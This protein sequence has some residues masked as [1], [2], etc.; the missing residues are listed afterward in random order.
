MAGPVGTAPAQDWPCLIA[1]REAWRAALAAAGA[2]RVAIHMEDSFAFAGALL[3]AW[4]AGCTAI[5]PGDATEITAASLEDGADLFLGGFPA[6]ETGTRRLLAV[7]QPGPAPAPSSVTF[8]LP[9]P[10]VVIFTSGSSGSPLAV[11]KTASDLQEEVATLESVLGAELPAVTAPGSGSAACVLATVSHQHIYGLLFR[12]LW[13]L[14]AGRP[15]SGEP[16]RFPEELF[17]SIRAAA[18]PVLLVAS[19]A[20]LRRLPEARFPEARPGDARAQIDGKSLAAVFS[21]GGPLPWTC[22]PACAQL[23]GAVP[24]EIYGSSETGGIAWRRRESEAMPWTLF[25]RVEIDAG[26]EGNLVLTQSPHM[27]KGR[28]FATR[29][30]VRMLPQGFQLQGRLDRI[31]KLEEKRLSLEAMEALLRSHPRV[32]EAHLTVSTG[33]GG[34]EG[35]VAGDDNGKRLGAVLRLRSG[36]IPVR[37][38]DARAELVQ[39]LRT[40]LLQGFERALL[41]KRWRLVAAMPISAAGKVIQTDLQALFRPQMG[42]VILATS[43]LDNGAAMLELEIPAE[44]EHFRGHFP[45]MPLLPGV[46]QLDWAIAQGVRLFGPFGGFLGLQAIKFQRPIMPGMRI[47]L[48]LARIKDKAG[49]AFKYES[50]LGRHASGQALFAS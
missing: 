33:D 49:V 31:V 44:L 46:V 23:L 47:R 19:P 10:P 37:G 43:R 41:P 9:N 12:C 7:P 48:E 35:E 32:A 38:S 5:L 34:G 14:A 8:T 42:P 30:G 16:I 1:S 40:H 17:E 21:S 25:P 36:D 27:E 50:S 3:G 29:D 6:G 13:P 11:E 18:G 4:A 26:E 39:S 20:F 45:H 15:F 24:V 22:V 2:R 28:P